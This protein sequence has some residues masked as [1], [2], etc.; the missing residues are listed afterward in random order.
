MGDSRRF[1]VFADLIHQKFPDVEKIADVAGGK[2][3]LQ[4]ELNKFGYDVTTFDKNKDTSRKIKYVR[5]YFNENIEEEFDLLVGLHPD[6]ATDII[7]R[8]ASRRGIP[9]MICPCCV[10][11]TAWQIKTPTDF[12]SWYN[13]LRMKASSLD[14]NTTTVYSKMKG[15]NRVLIGVP[16]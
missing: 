12:D 10:M 2:G 4:E 13:H 1:K 11:P 8:E 3:T 9:F 14:F 5:K 15:M 7:I 16:R 6:E